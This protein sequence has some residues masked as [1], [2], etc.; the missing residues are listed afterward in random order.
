MSKLT[1]VTQEE[2]RLLG[3]EF[4]SKCNIVLPNYSIVFYIYKELQLK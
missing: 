2:L 3:E 1:N 4:K